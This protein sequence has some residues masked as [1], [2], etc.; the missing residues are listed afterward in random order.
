[1]P[2][3]EVQ[4][5]GRQTRWGGLRDGNWSVLAAQG[6]RAAAASSGKTAPRPY[7]VASST[8]NVCP[9]CGDFVPKALASTLI[10]PSCS[11][12]F[13]NEPTYKLA[14]GTTV[15]TAP[16]PH[17][18]SRAHMPTSAPPPAAHAPGKLPDKGFPGAIGV[19]PGA[20]DSDT[21]SRTGAP[22]CWVQR[23][24]VLAVVAARVGVPLS[25]LQAT[26]ESFAGLQKRLEGSVVG[27]AS[28]IR[29]AAALPVVPSYLKH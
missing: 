23:E 24:H 7:Q 1:M 20:A 21:V 4:S 26:P 5:Q 29:C 12:L 15:L 10:C 2:R 18:R 17:G 22:I 6:P 27:Q 9:H 16:K 3:Q 11:T 14:L 28:A 19:T 13:L 25:L 8:P